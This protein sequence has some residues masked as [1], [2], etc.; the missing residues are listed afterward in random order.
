[1]V[2]QLIADNVSYGCVTIWPRNTSQTE[3]LEGDLKLGPLAKIGEGFVVAQNLSI[4]VRVLTDMEREELFKYRKY[5]NFI[6][7][8][9]EDIFFL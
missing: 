7:Y 2:A 9:H 6:I 1:M 4:W 8:N 3:H 5:F